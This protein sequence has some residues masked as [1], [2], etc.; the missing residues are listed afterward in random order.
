MGFHHETAT[1]LWN[2]SYGVEL[3]NHTGS[4]AI[5][6]AGSYDF[7]N[8]NVAALLDNRELVAGLAKRLR[9]GWRGEL[10][11]AAAGTEQGR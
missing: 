10:P 6:N 5:S 2:R 3:Y 11:A 9:A 7:E 4:V 1:P 8:V